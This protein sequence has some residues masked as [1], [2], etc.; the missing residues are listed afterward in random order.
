M[1]TRVITGTVLVILLAALCVFSGTLAFP[2]VLGLCALMGVNEMLGCIGL[3]KNWI[4]SIC[5]YGLTAASTVLLCASPSHSFFITVFSAILFCIL[6]LLFGS[7]VLSHGAIPFEKV[8]I[9]I[10]TSTFVITGFI[11]L[12][13]LRDMEIG[14]YVYLLAFLGPWVTDTF[15]YFTGFL[16]GKT[17]LIPDVS[18]KKTVEGSVG[19]TLFCIGFFALY[20]FLVKTK[21]GAP[22][23]PVYAFAL[24]GLIIA[25]VSQIGDLIFSLIKRKYGIKDY[26]FIFPGHGGI[27]DRFDS[28]IASAP[29]LLIFFEAFTKW[30]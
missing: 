23:P 26:G 21:L 10:T 1:L 19:G 29:L 17:K 3:R 18:P 27:L 16:F 7:A 4:I 12:V 20:G 2:I 6:F 22:V 11:C 25:I 24:L 28:I 30:A 9:A 13:L 8:C 5:M 14:K 15:A